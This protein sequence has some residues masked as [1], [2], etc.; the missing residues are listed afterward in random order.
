MT[1]ATKIRRQ[2]DDHRERNIALWRQWAREL[3]E[4]GTSPRPLEVLQAAAALEIKDPGAV[5]EHDAAVLR[6]YLSFKAGVDLCVRDRAEKLAAFGGMD[7]LVSALEKAKAEVTRL[8]DA[9]AEIDNGADQFWKNCMYRAERE[10]PRLWGE[11]PKPR[12]KWSDLKEIND[13]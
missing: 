10:N 4:D 9:L 8:S 5:L 7:K 12:P 1:L 6:E 13:D 11:W 3:A 2:L